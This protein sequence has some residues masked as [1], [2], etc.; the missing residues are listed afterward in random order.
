MFFGLYIKYFGREKFL[1]ICFKKATQLVTLLP[2][3]VLAALTMSR[4]GQLMNS[5][6]SSV[7]VQ[8]ARSPRFTP[9]QIWSLVKAQSLVQRW[10][11]TSC[12]PTWPK[13]RGSSMGWVIFYRGTN[14][15]TR[16]TA[17]WPNHLP[18]TANANP[19]RV[20]FPWN[21]GGHKHS[22]YNTVGESQMYT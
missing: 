9:L 15:I 14:P 13:G 7:P 22:V 8:K 5:R 6:H 20:R 10:L 3:C 19:V 16:A 21:H 12:V 2:Y 11:L 18:A 4:A 1:K 17:L